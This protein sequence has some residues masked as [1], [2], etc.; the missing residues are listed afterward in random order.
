MDNRENILNCALELF[1]QKG[2]DA[3]GVQEIVEAAGITK[4]T[5][6]YYFK[7]KRGLLECLVETGGNRLLSELKLVVEKGYEFKDCLFQLARVYCACLS[8]EHLFYSLMLGL[9]YSPKENEA[10]KVVMP[11]MKAQY[12]LVTGIFEDAKGLLGNMNGRQEQFAIGFLGTLNCYIM[13]GREKNPAAITDEKQ[14]YGV[15]HQFLHGIF[16]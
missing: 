9:M 3:V 11:L 6:Y 7:S 5:L 4:P 10:H 12:E 8:K 15:V 14:I 1:S 13:V 16:S 2:Y